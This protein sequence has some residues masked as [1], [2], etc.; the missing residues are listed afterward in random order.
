MIVDRI[1]AVQILHGTI[2]C[3]DQRDGAVHFL[4][5]F[6]FVQFEI[7]RRV[8]AHIGVVHVPA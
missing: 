6:F 8:R 4:R 2:Q 5:G 7:A 1:A 3:H